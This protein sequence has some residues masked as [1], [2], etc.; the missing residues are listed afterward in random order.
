MT[1][2]SKKKFKTSFSISLLILIDV[3]VIGVLVFLLILPS[4]KNMEDINEKIISS[5]EALEEKQETSSSLKKMR[6]EYQQVEDDVE[7]INMVLP[8]GKEISSL[9]VQLEAMA[10]DAG[11]FCESVNPISTG[12]ESGS[13]TEAVGEE[14]TKEITF[15]K[16][17]SVS[18]ELSGSYKSFKK[19]LSDIEKNIR[20]IDITSITISK[21]DS[22]EGEENLLDFDLELKTYYQ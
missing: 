21:A 3:I 17:L 18:V 12:E 9:L 7:K 4:Y 15:Y 14:E 20:I 8:Q 5:R 16:P 11:L 13:A 2:D 10:L 22:K 6:E 1:F 19:Y